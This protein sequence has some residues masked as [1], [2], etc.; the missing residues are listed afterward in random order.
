[1][2]FKVNNALDFGAQFV[3]N[4]YRM[5][6]QDGAYSIPLKEGALWFFGDTLIGTRSTEKSLW[7]NRGEPVGGLDMS[8]KGTIDKMITNTGLILKDDSGDKSLNDFQYILDSNGGLKNLIPL[9][10]DEDHDKIRI[11]CQHGIALNDIVYLSFIKVEMFEKPKSGLPVEFEIHGSGFARGKI[12]E[13]EFNRLQNKGSDIWWGID[14]PRF[15]SAMYCEGDWIYCFGV[16][17]GTD[18]IQ[19]CYLARVKTNDIENFLDFEYLS[20][21]NGSWS[22]NIS[23]AIPVFTEVPNELSVSYNSYLNKYLAVHSFG[24]S[25]KIVGRTANNLWGPW[26]EPLRLWEVSTVHEKPLP[27]PKL[28][29]AGKEHP[30]LSIDNGKTIFITYVEFEEYFPHLVQ[31]RLDKLA[32]L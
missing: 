2:N 14:E 15:A 13:W 22:K 17:Q 9:R 18:K 3:N 32:E 21:P 19:Q 4:E 23:E 29:Y 27:Y 26:S 10:P 8:G 31:I 1:L 20:S 16:K 24:L 6:G 28:I 11:W 5:V 12:G 30:E 25:G 7:Y